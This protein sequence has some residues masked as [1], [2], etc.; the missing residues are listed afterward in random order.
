MKNADF[1]SSE[2]PD[3]QLF[4]YS[5]SCFFEDAFKIDFLKDFGS[6]LILFGHVFRPVFDEKNDAPKTKTKNDASNVR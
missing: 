5:F 6:I 1:T 4:G 2:A 3:S